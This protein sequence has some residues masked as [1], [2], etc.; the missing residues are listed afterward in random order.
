MSG[1]HHPV[2]PAEERFNL[3]RLGVLPLLML[4]VGLV[5]LGGSLVWGFLDTKRFAFGWLVAFMY[6]FT[7]AGGCLFWTLIHHAVDCDWSVV[8]RRLM[9][10]VCSL[11]F[12][13]IALLFIPILL[14]PGKIYKWWDMDP[15]T[16]HLLAH[17]SLVL[18][19]GFFWGFAIA[20]LSFFAGFAWLMRSMSVRQDA[21]GDPRLSIRMRQFAYAGLILFALAISFAGIMWIMALD[22]HWFSTMWGVYIFAGSAGT[23]LAST[24]LITNALK[25]AGYFKGV[26][27]VEH[28]HIMGK[29][30][31]AFTIFWG[32]IA[33]SQY[34][35]YY[36]ANIPE[37]TI[38]F[39]Q[40]NEGGWHYF[41]IFLVFARF[42]FPF[43]LLLTQA[44]KRNPLRLCFAATWILCMHFIDLYWMIMPQY[45]VNTASVYRGVDVKFFLDVATL[46]GM[47]AV[48]AF[49]FLRRLPQSSLF[50]KR[51]PRLYESVTLTN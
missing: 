15:H 23:G 16:D 32:Y 28:N 14:L 17:K 24:I 13:W 9:E 47:L 36:Y 49:V 45:Q 20:A 21:S 25:A 43:L 1:H 18:N 50:P 2:A 8:V 34:M 51:D 11:F 46:V 26:I 10:Q 5:L 12:P 37:E 30:L 6:V 29:L 19:H 4:V 33:F 31:L 44:A 41:S 38:F 7:V 22:Y 3:T 40:R 35:L 39:H 42:F 27:T 48:L